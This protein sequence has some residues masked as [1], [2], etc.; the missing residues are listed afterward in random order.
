MAPAFN[1]LDRFSVAGNTRDRAFSHIK[2]SCAVRGRKVLD[3]G[4]GTGTWSRLF[5]KEGAFV[6]AIDFAP[7]MIEIAKAENE[8]I[9]FK[10]AGADETSRY[11]SGEFDIVTSS[12]VLHDILEPERK[13][14]LKE[15]NRIADLC[16]IF[17]Y[18]GHVPLIPR[19]FEF[20]EGNRYRNFLINI[21]SELNELIGDPEIVD[22]ENGGALYICR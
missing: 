11:G 19:L 6:E 9:D 2:E 17:D 4:C 15:M 13:E 5:Q 20:F 10:V 21:R 18:G 3:I 1:F 16:I 14:L 7:K 12:F 22:L 8:G